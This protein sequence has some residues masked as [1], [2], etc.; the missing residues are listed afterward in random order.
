M[1]L[2]L[3]LVIDGICNGARYAILGMG[4]ALIFN[5]QRM[6]DIS[7]G[8]IYVWCGF[9]MWILIKKMSISVIPASI[10]V[11]GLSFVISYVI[12]RT[13]MRAL[14]IRSPSPVAILLGSFA[15]LMAME[16]MVSI[17]WGGDIRLARSG[18]RVFTW[19]F[20]RISDIKFYSVLT[21][22]VI[23]LLFECIF[24]R[25]PIGINARAIASNPQLSKIVG[26]NTEKIIALTTCF[27]CM[28]T[29][30]D[31]ILVSVDTGVYP[32]IGFQS[33]MIGFM[34]VILGGIGSFGGAALGGFS[35]GFIRTIAVWQLPT[36]W[37]ELILF[38]IL[39]LII[40]FRPIGMFGVKDWKS[41][42]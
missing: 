9:A 12:Q 2:F 22:I 25:T 38:I 27:G 14:R 34:A 7:F 3:S 19:S 41:E 1:E 21:A 13:Y 8:G 33:V 24:L 40:A 28:I 42:V 20:I 23:Y 16:A 6:F 32:T 37:Q 18:G 29:T 31:A 39:F 36:L 30:M 11:L 26:M 35:I 4:F 15:M 5:T 17:I 10:I